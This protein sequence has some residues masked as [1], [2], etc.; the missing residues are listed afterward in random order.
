MHEAAPV[1]FYQSTW[2]GQIETFEQ[3]NWMVVITTANRRQDLDP[4]DSMITLALLYPRACITTGHQAE[5]YWA[6]KFIRDQANKDLK[7]GL[8]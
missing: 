5:W 1:E 8:F 2:E 6:S 7:R 4:I 3:E